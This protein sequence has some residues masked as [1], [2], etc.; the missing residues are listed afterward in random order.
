MIRGIV[1]LL[2]FG[3]L[4]LL[5]SFHEILSI[6]FFIFIV[7]IISIVMNDT[8]N[9]DDFQDT[10]D[11]YEDDNIAPEGMTEDQVI[12]NLFLYGDKDE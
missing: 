10:E 11:N 3:V 5:F 6:L 9:D 7:F 1:I 2:V 4:L 12:G 8:E